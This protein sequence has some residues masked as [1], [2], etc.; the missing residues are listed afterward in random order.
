MKF[1]AYTRKGAELALCEALAGADGITALAPKAFTLRSKGK[2]RTPSPVDVPVL[3]RIVFF[4]VKGEREWHTVKARKEVVGDLLDIS[5]QAWTAHVVPFIRAS[6]EEYDLAVRRHMAGELIDQYTRG[7]KLKVGRLSDATV[8]FIERV[9]RSFDMH[10]M[11]KA[12]GP[13]GVVF[14][15]PLDVRALGL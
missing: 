11:I 14:V 6:D 7:Q 5:R 13:M 9:Q 10:P 3:P 1:A 12:D 15:D 2:S 8:T 4:S